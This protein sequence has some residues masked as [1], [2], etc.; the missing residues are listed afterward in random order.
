MDDCYAL[1]RG[2]EWTP[3]DT[4]LERL[5]LTL[6]PITPYEE[7]P[8]GQAAGR[9]LALPAHARRANPPAANSAVDGY[10]F[11]WADLPPADA[12]GRVLL[13]LGEGRA[14]AGQPLPKALPRGHAVRIL[15]GAEMPKGTDTVVL[16]EDCAVEGSSLRFPPP[17]KAG[18]NRRKAGE[19]AQEGDLLL[20][21]C[22]KLAPQ[23]LARLAVAG[24]GL[25]GV[26]RQLRVAVLSTGDELIQPGAAPGTDGIFDANRP[27]LLALVEALGY[28]A[29]DLGAV[30]DDE[31][32]LRA[33]LHRGAATADAIL[34][35]GGASAGDEDHVSRLLTTEG[36]VSTWRIAVK[37]GRPL[38]IGTWGEKPIFGLPG[39]PVAAWICALIFARP[40]LAQLAGGRWQT[41]RGYALPAA[42][43]K[44]KKAGR[45]E[46]LRARLDADG[47][48]EAFRSEGSGL[49]GGLSWA[50]GLVELPDAAMTVRRGDPVRFIP[51]SG[52]GIGGR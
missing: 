32:A 46:Y 23:D 25:V 3:V 42:F 13:P 20:P 27:M 34:T 18:A 38:A 39:N 26:R 52:F 5:R 19:D 7:V 51:W 33:A 48:V 49:V 43:E 37:P 47:R 2:T 45:R 10:A 4:A 50:D 17:E 24:V 16:Q 15:T 1:P 21:A 28:A 8:L 31:A 9:V 22:H 11:L 35:S 36:Q 6:G 14:A 30:R 40:A 12:D 29:V 44:R 41:P